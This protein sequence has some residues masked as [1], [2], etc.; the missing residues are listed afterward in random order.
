MGDG[1][2]GDGG[3]NGAL[4]LWG[5]PCDPLRD[6]R[7]RPSFKK[8]PENQQFVSLRAAAGWTQ[9]SIATDMRIDEKTLRK[10][11]SR[12][13]SDGALHVEGKILD[14]LMRR[15]EQGH[16]AAARLLLDRLDQ[17]AAA[18]RPRKVQAEDDDD[19]AEL[20][21][22]RPVGKKVQQDRNAQII[23]PDWAETI[24]RRGRQ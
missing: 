15:V 19:D 10:N 20:S 11:F 22:V 21:D 5:N 23:P 8:T 7:G 1:F 14:M 24:N 18:P 13:L 16:V 2:S 4:D 12:E 6:R 17:N 9:K 3:A